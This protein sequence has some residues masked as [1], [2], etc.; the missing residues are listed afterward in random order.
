MQKKDEGERGENL[1]RLAAQLFAQ[2]PENREEALMVLTIA[3]ELVLWSVEGDA[4]VA[5][6]LR[7]VGGS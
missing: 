4:I 2:L 6:V 3:R 5:P 7:I 1:K